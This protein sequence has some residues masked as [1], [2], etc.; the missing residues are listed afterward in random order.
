MSHN[1][2]KNMSQLSENNFNRFQNLM[3]T[4]TGVY[5]APTKKSLIEGR[6]SKRL[7]DLNITDYSVY[8]DMVE[9]D[10]SGNE[11]QIVINSL[12]TNET[13]F[14]REDNHFIFLK[15]FVE[16]NS[17]KGKIRVWS[18][19]CSTG[20]EA[21]SIAMVL[22]SVLGNHSKWEV[23]ASD[24]SEAVLSKAAAGLYPENKGEKIPFELKKKYCLKGVNSN[25]GKFIVDSSLRKNVKFYNINL[26]EKIPD[27]G[28]FDIIF[29]RNVLIY[30]DS[31]SKKKVI[32]NIYSKIVSGGYLILGH[33]E[34]LLDYAKDFRKENTTT[35]QKP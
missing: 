33:S 21:Y 26:T 18:A 32:D 16:K 19:A 11:L 6:M 4:V 17:A 8:L 23:S 15:K 34:S 24:I 35:Y 27:I 30:F 25:A 13:Y 22:D 29:L 5:L 12:T 7:R 10:R 9:K 14:F 20:E 28:S 31:E 3:Y 2:H 1:I